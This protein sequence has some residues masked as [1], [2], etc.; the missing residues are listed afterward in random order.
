MKYGIVTPYTSLLVVEDRALRSLNLPDRSSPVDN[1]QTET[2]SKERTIA[3][4][5]VDNSSVIGRSALE[6]SKALRAAGPPP[7][8]VPTNAPSG[9]NANNQNQFNDVK[10][11]N[12]NVSIDG[13]RVVDIGSN[14]GTVVTANVDAVREVKPQTNGP[15]PTP[16][17]IVSIQAAQVDTRAAE[18]QLLGSV[19]NSKAENEMKNSD[20]LDSPDSY[21]SNIRTVGDKTFRL[22]GEEWIDTDFKGE[23]KLP[24]I[25]IQFGSEEFFNLVSKEPKL[26][27]YFALGKK[28]TV[29]YKGSV[30]HVVE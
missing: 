30:Y 19:L 22:K 8:N 7:A 1:I 20:K 14:N 5:Q 24:E 28:L 6:M 3:A 2:G 25:K 29:V 12:K 23:S 21:L 10:G 27:E 11:E 18:A 4:R 15:I 26:A 9:M 16:T 13:S 17:N